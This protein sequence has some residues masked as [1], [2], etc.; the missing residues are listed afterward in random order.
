MAGEVKEC[1]K[2]HLLGTFSNVRKENISNLNFSDPWTTKSQNYL[3][4]KKIIPVVVFFLFWG[5][6]LSIKK[7]S[8]SIIR[9][10]RML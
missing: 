9:K 10:N 3:R 6:F 7:K 5:A 4:E 8:N 1:K 2:S